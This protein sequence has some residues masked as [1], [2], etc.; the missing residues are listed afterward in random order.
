MKTNKKKQWC[1]VGPEEEGSSSNQ[2]ALVAFQMM[3][4]DTLLEE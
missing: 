1:T 4:G 3:F 2:P